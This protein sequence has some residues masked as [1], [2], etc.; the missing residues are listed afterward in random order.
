MKLNNTRTY[1]AFCGTLLFLLGFFG[2]AFRSSFDLPNK[3]L[4]LALL[5]GFWGIVI[6]F[7]AQ[8]QN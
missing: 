2:F 3:Y 8:K 1:T 5:L 4:I 6:S 7:S